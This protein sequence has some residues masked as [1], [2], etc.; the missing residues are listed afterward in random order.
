[1]I[2]KR[3]LAEAINDVSLA[4]STDNITINGD[5]AIYTGEKRTIMVTHHAEMLQLYEKDT[6]H[7]H[8][9]TLFG[10]NIS[11]SDTNIKRSNT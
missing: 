9:D 10:Y 1:M 11:M 5:Y 4:D 6:L 7:L 2:K 8:G 3:I